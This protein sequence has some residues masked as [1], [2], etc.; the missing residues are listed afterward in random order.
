MKV[1]ETDRLIIRHMTIDDAGFMRRLLNEPSWVQFI[2]DRGVKTIEDA[3]NYILTGPLQMQARLGFSFY[4][5]ELKLT[6]CAAGICGLAKREYLDDVDIGYALLP[7]YCGLGYAHEASAAV[8]EYAKTTLGLERVVATTR[9]HNHPS[10]KLLVKLGL[11]F[12]TTI[13]HPEDGRALQLYAID[14][15]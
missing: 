7:E 15:S 6:G 2:G 14:F 3:R 5:V 13:Q 9:V 4:V 10:A 8:L 11:Q 12:E 1:L